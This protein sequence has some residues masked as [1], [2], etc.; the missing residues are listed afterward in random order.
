MHILLPSIKFLMSFS[1]NPRA[2]AC[3]LP[4]YV[5]NILLTD[6]FNIRI[7]RAQKESINQFNII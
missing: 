5:I 3:D 7:L 2:C 4:V 6:H 1:K